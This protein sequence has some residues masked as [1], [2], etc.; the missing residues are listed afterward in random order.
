[1]CVGGGLARLILEMGEAKKACLPQWRIQGI[2]RLPTWPPN[3]EIRY[4]LS[5][6]V[7]FIASFIVTEYSREYT[8]QHSVSTLLS[9]LRAGQ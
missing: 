9:R 7:N 6:T 3:L 2:L 1:V 5:L 4:G 8:N